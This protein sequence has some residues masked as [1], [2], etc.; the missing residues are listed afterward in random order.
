MTNKTSPFD[1]VALLSA[2]QPSEPPPERAGGGLETWQP[3]QAV[4]RAQAAGTER[5]AGAL[6]GASLAEALAPPWH[7][8]VGSATERA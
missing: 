6:S 8:L 7:D 4:A 2:F 5:A 3:Q 1:A